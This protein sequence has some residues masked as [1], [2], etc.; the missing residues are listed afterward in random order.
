MI[1]E[2][3][4]ND[5]NLIAI[6]NQVLSAINKTYNEIMS[7][8]QFPA[9]ELSTLMTAI[10]IEMAAGMMVHIIDNF[11]EIRENVATEEFADTWFQEVKQ[12]FMESADKGLH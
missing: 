5:P 6:K 9:V 1:P 11:P 3:M 8:Q 4:Q 2:S 10:S 7:K 12:I